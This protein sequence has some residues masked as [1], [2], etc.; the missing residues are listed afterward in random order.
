MFETE[1]SHKSRCAGYK[2]YDIVARVKICLLNLFSKTENK[3]NNKNNNKKSNSSRGSSGKNRLIGTMQTRMRGK[4]PV[5]I[6]EARRS[7]DPTMSHIFLSVP[8]VSLCRFTNSDQ[9]Q[10]TQHWIVSRSAFAGVPENNFSPRPEPAVD[11][12]DN[13]LNLEIM[14]RANKIRYCHL[15][16]TRQAYFRW[17]K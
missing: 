8:V 17:Y 3:K 11:G 4:G 7:G 16:S 15:N 1:N 12:P 9:T 5:H 6:T 13:K 14:T 2:E 10:V